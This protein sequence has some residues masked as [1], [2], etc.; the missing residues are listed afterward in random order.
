MLIWADQNKAVRPTRTLSSTGISI[1]L[2]N[3]AKRFW[4][5]PLFQNRKEEEKDGEE[6]KGL[7]RKRKK[8][9]RPLELIFFFLWGKRVIEM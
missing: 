6:R 8:D 4:S 5:V 7:Y 9:M 3:P 1:Q 2:H